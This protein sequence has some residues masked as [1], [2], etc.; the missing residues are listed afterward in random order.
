MKRF[1]ILA[2][3]VAFFAFSFWPALMDSVVPLRAE[4]R[5]HDV[6]PS[7][8]EDV[9]AIARRVCQWP[10]PLEKDGLLLAWGESGYNVFRLSK[11]LCQALL[12]TEIPFSHVGELE[13][14]FSAFGIDI[15]A[16]VLGDPWMSGN[17]HA[18]ASS[19]W[20]RHLMVGRSDAR[21]AVR[22]V[23][24]P[25]FWPRIGLSHGTRLS[26]A[27]CSFLV[28]A[29]SLHDALDGEAVDPI[30]VRVADDLRDEG[31]V[32]HLLVRN[33]SVFELSEARVGHLVAAFAHWL[34]SLAG[35][36]GRSPG[37]QQEKAAPGQ[38]REPNWV[39]YG[40]GIRLSPEL[41]AVAD[42]I[43]RGE[44][45]YTRV[46]LSKRFVVRGHFRRQPHGPGRA[47][48]K[49]IWVAPHWKGPEGADAW[50]HIYEA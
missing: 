38:G 47:E 20:I 5:K 9:A 25:R 35:H 13:L 44:C 16:G 8:L 37:V 11:G 4:M 30:R 41:V 17:S 33:A 24:H 2:A 7:R 34:S 36:A 22:A 48:R 23:G 49:T 3:F 28:E 19:K 26:L 32:D 12:L 27:S 15:P 29:E 10:P 14:P 6:D 50:A 21:L 31:D 1:S 42:D 40:D 43:A 45:S 39:S 46:A 18:H